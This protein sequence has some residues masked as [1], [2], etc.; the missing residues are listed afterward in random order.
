MFIITLIALLSVSVPAF[1]QDAMI[2][3]PD[4]PQPMMR[5]P[6]PGGLGG[7]EMW[8]PMTSERHE[9]PRYDPYQ[10]D[11]FS[12]A[13]QQLRDTEQA[14]EQFLREHQLPLRS[15]VDTSPSYRPY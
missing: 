4:G 14:K 2:L 11:R 5:I 7:M 13:Y 15:P 6:A 3:T 10:D 12:R 1:A 9:A 8:V